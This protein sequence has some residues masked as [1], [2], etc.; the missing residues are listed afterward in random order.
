MRAASVGAFAERIVFIGST[1]SILKDYFYNPY[2]RDRITTLQRLT[3][4]Q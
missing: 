4:A 1:A 2:S 3:V